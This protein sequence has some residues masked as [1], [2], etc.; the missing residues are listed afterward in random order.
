MKY[1]N[2]IPAVVLSSHTSGMGVIRALGVKGVPVYSISYEDTDMGYKSKYVKDFYFSPHPEKDAE[3]FIN[4]LLQLHSKI[5]K[6]MLIPADDA[7]VVLVSKHKDFL[8]KYFFISTLEWDRAKLFIE[9]K[10]TYKL[11]EEAGIPIPKTI[12]PNSELD[13]LA[14]AVDVMFPCLIKPSESHRYFELFNKKVEIANNPEQLL[15]AYKEAAAFNLEVMIQELIPGG[16]ENG[17]NYNSFYLKDYP[18][19]DFSAKKVRQSPP[20]FGVP[21]VVKSS[22]HIEEVAINGRKII[23]ALSFEGYSCVEFKYD[24]RDNKYK[25]MELNG[26]H[27]R[28]VILAVKCGINFPWIEYVHATQG[29][30]PEVSRYNRNIYWIDEFRD[31][32][33][34]PKRILSEK[35]SAM[36]YLLPYFRKKVYSNFEFTD[37]APFLKR[38]MDSLKA[39]KK[40]STLKKNREEKINK[41]KNKNNLMVN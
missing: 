21:C 5:G 34:T 16:D 14:Y 3:G 2:K 40:N 24:S 12:V 4:I 26:R 37:P 15:Q 32:I 38:I 13:V 9:K 17:V 11:A 41:I 7:T 35:Y 1:S 33:S 29:E 6:S 31:T 10:F 8:S 25:L 36:G 18:I 39:L 28:S 22:D 30:I 27:N 20:G 19:I 23:E